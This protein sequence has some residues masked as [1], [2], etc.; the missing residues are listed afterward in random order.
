MRIS[1]KALHYFMTAV[2]HGSIARAAEALNVVPSAVSAAIDQ[3]EQGF[4]LQL[5][6]R[7]PAKGI[8]PTTSGRILLSKVRH[9]LEEYETLL[10]AGADLR[11]ALTGSL[12]VGY[13]APVAPAFLP[14]IAAPLLAE[15]PSVSLQFHECNN[16]TAQAGLLDGTFDVILFVAENVRPGI[17]YDALLTVPPYL[18]M[19]AAHRLSDQSAIE[20]R[21]LEDEPLVLLDR[22][23]VGEYYRGILEAVGV[24]P[25]IAATGTTHEMIR[26]L[27]GA[28]AGCAILNMRPLTPVSYAG[29]SLISRPLL[30]KSRPLQLV[31]GRLEDNPRRLVRAF[32]ERCRAYFLSDEAR[33]LVVTG[34]NGEQAA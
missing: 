30:S 29:D 6:T 17:A 23:V 4:A 8:Q 14:A 25:R 28:G 7:F 19:A 1:L 20:P 5:I 21:D 13:Y 9:L 15:N 34:G 3:V 16:E 18:L 12:K 27:V 2:D 32:I 31:L 33:R 24:T 22:P 26:A 10:T 11:N